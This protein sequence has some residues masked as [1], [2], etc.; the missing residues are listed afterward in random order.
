MLHISK[1]PLHYFHFYSL[2]S[3]SSNCP[4]GGILRMTFGC[5]GEGTGSGTDWSWIPALFPIV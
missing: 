4:L 5:G 3:E 2:G 1:L